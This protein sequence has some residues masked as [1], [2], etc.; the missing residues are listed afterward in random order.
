MF[1]ASIP[2]LEAWLSGAAFEFVV[3]SLKSGGWRE[4]GILANPTTVVRQ[5]EG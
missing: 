3:L 5:E 4:K 2:R 1:G